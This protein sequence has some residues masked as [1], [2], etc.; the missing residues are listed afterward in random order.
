[1]A[2]G[3]EFV[4]PFDEPDRAYAQQVVTV[5]TPILSSLSQAFPVD[6]EVLLQDF[7]CIP[8]SIAAIANPV[9]GRSI[10]G[11]PTNAALYALRH[12]LTSDNIGYRSETADGTPLRSSAIY[13]WGPSGRPVV[14]LCVNSKIG[15]IESA[16]RIL[17]DLTGLVPEPAVAPVEAVTEEVSPAN[18]S[19]LSKSILE[20]AIQ[21][22]SVPVDLMQKEHRLDVVRLL[23]LRSY[24]ALRGSVELVAEELGVS[25]F[26]VY[27]YLDEV[28]AGSV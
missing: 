20:E 16:A 25:R 17:G 2:D 19:A 13:F 8:H 11:P 12:N 10:G 23:D 3:L 18:L 28:R 21:Q 9:T 24:F 4:E 27:N 7:T 1:M 22:T 14:C 15:Q 6:T 26:T 5:M